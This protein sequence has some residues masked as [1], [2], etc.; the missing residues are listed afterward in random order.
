[1]QHT[2][3]AR[4]GAQLLGLAG[5]LAITFVAGAIGAAASRNAS[6]FYGQLDL[7]AWAPPATVFGP[8][9]TALYLGMAIAAWLVWRRHGLRDARLPL[10]L[11]VVQLVFNALWSWLFFGWHLG[12]ASFTGLLLLW[13]LICATLISFW[14]L[15]RLA[16]WLLAPYLAWV[17]F[18]G[19]LNLAAWR[20]NLEL[21]R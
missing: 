10:T 8:V 12:A 17:T 19:A 4:P 3:Q 5:W 9:W 6:E 13:V 11:F 21:L 2:H 1:M 7:P 18:A 16:A 14:P 20:M 15:H